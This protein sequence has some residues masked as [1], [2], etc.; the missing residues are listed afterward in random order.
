MRPVHIPTPTNVWGVTCEGPV[1]SAIPSAS[2]AY[3]ILD[4]ALRAVPALDAELGDEGWCVLWRA[5]ARFETGS[6]VKA[7]LWVRRSDHGRELAEKLKAPLEEASFMVRVGPRI[8]DA[9][10]GLLP[11]VV[12]LRAGSLRLGLDRCTPPLLPEVEVVEEDRADIDFGIQYRFGAQR[13]PAC[14]VEDVPLALVAGFPGP[15]LL[16]SAAL[17]E[18]ALAGCEVDQRERNTAR[19][20]RCGWDFRAR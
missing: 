17:G 18:V 16:L 5:E 9:H 12:Y 1:A 7:L 13:C 14:R 19:C 3:A 2:A 20:R 11:R 10:P 8:S 15:E 4:E 6:L